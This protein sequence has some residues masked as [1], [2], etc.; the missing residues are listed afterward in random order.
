MSSD[1]DDTGRRRKAA[2]LL[3]PTTHVSTTLD[4]FIARANEELVEIAAAP[5]KPDHREG[6]LRRELEEISAKLSA[7]EARAAAAEARATE[8]TAL[9]AAAGARAAGSRGAT[10]WGLTIAAFVMGGAAMLAVSLVVRTPDH[11]VAP[12]AQAV[13]SRPP[14]APAVTAEPLAAPVPVAP[15]P[16]AVPP[17]VADMAV[18]SAPVEKVTKKPAPKPRKPSAREQG[19]ATPKPPEEDLYNPF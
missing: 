11:E 10:R 1:P 14:P 5:F 17:Q 3:Q 4:A 8:A 6:V 16:V 18:V 15:A 19:T 13:T 9:V 12:P 2:S 7:A